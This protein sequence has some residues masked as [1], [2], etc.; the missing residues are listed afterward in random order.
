MLFLA[1][2]PRGPELTGPARRALKLAEVVGERCPVTLAAPSPSE[3]PEGPFRVLETGPVQDQRLGAAFAEHDVAVVQL[4]PSPR[5]LIGAIRRSTR[6]VV[7]VLTPVALEVSELPADP[8][9][10]ALISWRL[11]ELL[12]YLVAA[13]LV[14]CTNE[15]QRDLLI[16]TV[17]GARLLDPGDMPSGSLAARIAVVPHGIDEEAPRHT[18]TVLRGTD[19]IGEDDRVV[20]WA[21]GIWSWFDPLTP[22]KAVE[23]LRATRPD[24]KLVFAA[25]SHPDSGQR[26]AHEAATQA[27]IHYARARGLEGEGVIFRPEWLSRED[28]MNLLLESDV[29]ILTTPSTLEA[30][31]GTR[32]RV[33]DYL[34]AGL[35]VVCTT[36]DALSAF[37]EVN[38]VGRAVEPYDS[39]ACAK[40]LDDLTGPDR[41]RLDTRAALA[42]LHWRRVSAPLVDFCLDPPERRGRAA[43][44]FFAARQ[45]PAF[46][47]AV[48]HEHR[49]A[50]VARTVVGRVRRRT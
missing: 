19:S 45:Y 16:G 18:R 47:R 31:F 50:D 15:R 28:Y 8:G 26:R 17:L 10:R 44:I 12:A 37:I 24:V 39:Y 33:L 6:L 46:A 42:P 49:A 20:V 27:A 9:R 32:T 29:G 2:V 14:L 11:R 38:R 48:Y 22:I 13:D 43:S 4:L 25:M 34:A 7:D 41:T 35:P 40:I 3:F 30:R 36:T 1:A 21:G 23:T 5:H